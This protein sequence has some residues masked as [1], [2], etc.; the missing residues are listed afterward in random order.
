MEK[1]ET[2]QEA[3]TETLRT[4]VHR[5]GIS[6]VEKALLE[7]HKSA[8]GYSRRSNSSLP[9]SEPCGKLKAE[10]KRNRAFTFVSKLEVSREI[11]CQL[12][13]LAR[14]YDG[15]D[16]L[17]TIGELRNF[18]QIYK[19]DAP[20]SFSRDSA[21]PRVFKFLSQLDLHE[22]QSIIRTNSFSGPARLGPIADAIR[23]AS[24]HRKSLPPNEEEE[25][26]HSAQR[27]KTTSADEL[28]THPTPAKKVAAR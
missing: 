14:R 17:P 19:I 9:R 3:L 11:G 6:R 23:G 4:I 27:M 16:F 7:I 10:K 5:Y 12:D 13:E 2:D 20:K 8:D 22:I 18:F 25:N 1:L 28:S 21:I 15:R 24:K 26:N